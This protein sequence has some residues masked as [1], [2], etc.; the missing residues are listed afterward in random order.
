VRSGERG[1]PRGLHHQTT[2]PQA[3]AN[4]DTDDPLPHLQI[5]KST[6]RGGKVEV[7]RTTITIDM[8]A[9]DSI[10]RETGTDAR[11]FTPH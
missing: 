5:V 9:E 10:T 8:I 2:E 7:I 1:E 11:T 4:T 6:S 3:L